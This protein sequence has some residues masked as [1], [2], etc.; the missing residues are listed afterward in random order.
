MFLEAHKD[1]KISLNNTKSRVELQHLVHY[2]K[3][4]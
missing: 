3:S 1:Y 4:G 2:L